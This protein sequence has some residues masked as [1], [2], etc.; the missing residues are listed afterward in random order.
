MH[1]QRL[2]LEQQGQVGQVEF[3]KQ[4]VKILADSDREIRTMGFCEIIWILLQRLS[5]VKTGLKISGIR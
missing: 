2:E 3:I 1:R 4:G 5:D